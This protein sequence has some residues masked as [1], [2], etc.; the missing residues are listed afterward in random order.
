MSMCDKLNN[1]WENI[2]MGTDLASLAEIYVQG[3]KESLTLCLS[4][5]SQKAYKQCRGKALYIK[6]G[7][8]VSR[9]LYS[10]VKV[11]SCLLDRRLG[12]SQS[13]LDTV[14]EK[15]LPFQESKSSLSACSQLSYYLSYLG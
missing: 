14:T 8:V 1:T 12:R 10:W 2:N 11:P 13:H 7:R 5:M 15:I 3:V 6:W 4:A 9:M